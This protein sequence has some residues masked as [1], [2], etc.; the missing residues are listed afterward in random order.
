MWEKDLIVRKYWASHLDPKGS[1][2]NEIV[3]SLNNDTVCND[4]I[5]KENYLTVE[6]TLEESSLVTAKSNN[7]DFEGF[8]EGDLENLFTS[9]E[10]EEIFDT[11]EEGYLESLFSSSD[12]E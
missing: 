2:W 9:S 12:S 10:T 4:N 3:I 8:D 6:E 11:L 5:C 1:V 7:E